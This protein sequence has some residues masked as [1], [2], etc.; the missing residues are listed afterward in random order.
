MSLYKNYGSNNYDIGAT[1]LYDGPTDCFP[2]YFS[3]KL[4]KLRHCL[5]FKKKNSYQ[6]KLEL[7][8]VHSLVLSHV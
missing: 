4:E 8:L 1:L 2:S 6:L 3:L 5:I 7:N